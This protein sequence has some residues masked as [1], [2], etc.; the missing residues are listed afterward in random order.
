MVVVD[1][2]LNFILQS[3]AIV[4]MRLQRSLLEVI[5]TSLKQWPTD[6]DDHRGANENGVGHGKVGGPFLQKVVRVKVV[7]LRVKQTAINDR[8]IH[9]IGQEVT[10]NHLVEHECSVMLD[11][12]KVEEVKLTS[13]A[14][15]RP[16]CV[17]S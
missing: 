9:H 4:E 2:Q 8:Q 5:P 12:P 10:V 17:T 16:C 7:S 15:R 13:I 3:L 1:V 14:P 11:V 6:D